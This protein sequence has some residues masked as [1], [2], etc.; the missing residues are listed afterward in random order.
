MTVVP[1]Q[2]NTDSKRV[3]VEAMFDNIAPKY[4]LLNHTL[5]AGIDVL[6]RRKAIKILQQKQPKTILDIATGTADFAIEAKAL[7]PEKI[8][9]VDISEGMLAV[10]RTKINAKNL[11]H[12]ITLE[13]GDSEKL[14]FANDSFDAITCSF[15]VRNFE[16]LQLGLAEM[17][18]VLKPNGTLVIIEFSQPENFPIKQLYNFYFKN[19]LP[20]I[21]RMVSKDT[22]AYTYLPNS[23]KVFPYGKAFVNI[24]T[25]VGFT[26]AR[27]VSLTF[28]V[29]N[30]YVA[31]K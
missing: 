16:H 1:Y 5:S 18:R 8:V 24:L 9:G 6:W 31:S 14:I 26:E 25:T 28:G 20:L 10:G 3:Q 29:A 7:N 15:G 17:L 30:I 2:N 11:Q 21:G 23:V 12:I 4:D 19:I 22:A 27:A 13:T